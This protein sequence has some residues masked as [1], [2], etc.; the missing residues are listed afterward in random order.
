MKTAVFIKTNKTRRKL[1]AVVLQRQNDLLVSLRTV[2]ACSCNTRTSLPSFNILSKKRP[3]MK[4]LRTT[5]VIW[6]ILRVL[7]VSVFYHSY[8]YSL[9]FLSSCAAGIVFLYFQQNVFITLAVWEQNDVKLSVVGSQ[10]SHHWRGSCSDS[11]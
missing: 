4:N 3:L 11:D 10:K 6:F 7:F 1:T 9:F 5:V 8:H 2:T